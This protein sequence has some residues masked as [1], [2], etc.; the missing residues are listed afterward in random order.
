[1]KKKLVLIDGNSILNRTFYALPELTNSRGIHTNAVYGFVNILFKILDEESPEYLAVAF[2]VKMPTFR[3]DMYEGYKGTR[4]PM[5]PELQEQLPIVKELLAAMG[6]Q[7]MEKPGYEA[8]DVLGTLAKIGKTKGFAVSLVSGDRDML[9]LATDDTLI[10]IPK[11]KFG[12]TEIEDYY[13]DDVVSKYGVTPE[14]LIEVKALMGDASDN[15]PGVPGIGEK[16]ALKIITE[17]KDIENAYAHREEIKPARTS[18]LLGDNMETARMSRKLAAIDTKV[19]LNY[20]FEDFKLKNLL[21]KEAY[22]I[23]KDLEFKRLLS[24]FD[25]KHADTND[26]EESFKTILSMD[27]I[28]AVFEQAEKQPSAGVRAFATGSGLYGAAIAATEEN[29]Y[30][31]PVTD[32]NRSFLSEMLQSL[33]ASGIKIATTNLK[34]QLKYLDLE[35]SDNVYD[36]GIGAYLMNPLKDTYHHDDLARD[37]LEMTVPASEGLIGKLS[38]EAAAV[39]KPEEF[40]KYA[41]YCA[42][43]SLAACK[44]LLERLEESGMLDLYLNMEM[45]LLYALH[46]MEKVG[47][48]VEKKALEEYGHELGVRI[49]GLTKEIHTEIGRDF[50]INSPKQLGEIL[51]NEL[52]LP[53]AKK[54]KTGYSTSADIL[55]KLATEFPIVSK[56]LEYRQLTKLKSTYADGLAGYIGPDNRIHGTFNQTIAATG[57]ISSTEPNLQNIPI[58]VEMGRIIRKVFVPEP[59]YIFVDADYSQIELRILASLSGDE[60]LIR[61]YKEASDIHRITAAKVFNTP[62]EEVTN[63]QRN[64][65]KAVNFGIVYGISSF[66]LSQGLSITRKEAA[67][68]IEQYFKTYP[69]VKEFLDK[70]VEDAKKNGYAVTMFGRRRPVPEL[71]SS[72]FMQRSFGERVAMNSPIQGTAADII[73]IAML[74]VNRELKKQGLKSKI[75]LQVH[76]ELLVE[77]AIEEK[78]NVYEILNR[79]MTNAARMS[80]PLEIGIDEGYSWYDAH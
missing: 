44:P 46:E 54:T 80:V 3:H 70:S 73:K 29:I 27:E 79:E 13:A 17:F 53:F 12:S 59:G 31:I 6:I 60:N 16:T 64:N 22:Q 4:K 45:P 67:K 42:Y 58:R 23:F 21:T 43:V 2:D 24:R 8:D 62:L 28:R 55:E 15:I 52:K 78:E 72:N 61:A 20:D 47:I 32:E 69:K 33:F 38:P 50:N 65:A 74:N 35:Y 10:R 48:R 18:N 76:D 30:Y 11:T 19:P 49:E 36:L 57:R 26:I 63:T 71:K 41:C 77:A 9:Q 56:I 39:Q 37:Y 7:I 14:E 66:G 34:E 1:M 5:P 25:F 40:A 51:F 68:Y 75:V